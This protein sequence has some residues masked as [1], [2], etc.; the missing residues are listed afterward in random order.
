[1]AWGIATNTYRDW[2]S[3]RHPGYTLAR[4]LQIRAAKVWRVTVDFAVPFTNNRAEGDLRM[5][6]TKVKVSGTMRTLTGLKQFARI[7]G[8]VSSARKNG[9]TAWDALRDLFHG[10]PWQPSVT[11]ATS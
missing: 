1:M 6:K 5:A 4:R 10:N 7:R 2:P 11:H 8:Y 3:G 9:I